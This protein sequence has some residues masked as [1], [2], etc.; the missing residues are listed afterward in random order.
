[1]TEFANDSRELVPAQGDMK[2]FD[3]TYQEKWLIYCPAIASDTL[4]LMVTALDSY[5]LRSY[6]G[7][8]GVDAR[9]M[10]ADGAHTTG[11]FMRLYSPDKWKEASGLELAV[12]KKDQWATAIAEQWERYPKPE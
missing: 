5:S 8:L 7:R 12:T 4:L 6:G 11:E 9:G 3:K 10:H 2:G 1:M